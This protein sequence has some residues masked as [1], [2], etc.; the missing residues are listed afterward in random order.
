[1]EKQYLD[2][3][4]KVKRQQQLKALLDAIRNAKE[5]YMRIRR[6]IPVPDEPKEGWTYAFCEGL[7]L[8]LDTPDQWYSTPN[9]LCINWETREFATQNSVYSF[10][11]IED[12]D[13]PS[14]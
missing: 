1:M 5:G 8:H 6:F 4:Q 9:V 7:P 14:L 2:A 10:E 13:E 12:I 11:F 3:C